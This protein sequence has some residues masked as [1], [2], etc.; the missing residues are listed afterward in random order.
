MRSGYHNETPKWSSKGGILEKHLKLSKSNLG[1]RYRLGKK[2]EWPYGI[3]LLGILG[4]NDAKN[5]I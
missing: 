3:S 1:S 4:R 5:R 2:L